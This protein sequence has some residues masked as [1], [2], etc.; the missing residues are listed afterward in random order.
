[1]QGKENIIIG[2]N[3]VLQ[4]IEPVVLSGHIDTVNADGIANAC[5]E[6]RDFPLGNT[7]HASLN[8][9]NIYFLNPNFKYIGGSDYKRCD[10]NGVTNVYGY[11]G[12]VATDENGNYTTGCDMYKSW[13]KDANC[14]YKNYVE[15]A[16][17]LDYTINTVVYLPEGKDTYTYD[18]SSAD[19]ISAYASYI[20]NKTPYKDVNIALDASGRYLSQ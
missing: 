4:D 3:T 18:F 7:Y 1:M 20:D 14:V 15:N 9:D 5:T 17:T 2:I 10:N 8:I 13:T 16:E 19:N 11:G 6:L 12:S